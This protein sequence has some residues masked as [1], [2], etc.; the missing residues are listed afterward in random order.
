MPDVSQYQKIKNSLPENVTLVC[1]SKTYPVE[2]IKVIYNAGQR[3]F[4]EN[5]VQEILAKKDLLPNDIRW[6]LIGHLQTNKV[7]QILPY[8]SLIQSVD[9]EKLLNKIQQQSL[10]FGQVTSILLQ[11]KIAEEDTKYGIGFKEAELILEK[12]KE[13]NYPNIELKG[14]MGM[15]SFTE[16]QDQLKAEMNSLSSFYDAYKKQYSFSILS[17]GM[18]SDYSLAIKCGSN[19]VRIGSAIFGNR[20]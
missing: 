14:L 12:F 3:D 16:N 19:L 18:S 11:I 6:H 9:S 17:M 10:E 1:V 13:K 8:V 4:G 7:K 15:A 5:K 20:Y 2:D